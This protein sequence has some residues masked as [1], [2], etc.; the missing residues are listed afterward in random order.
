MLTT[1]VQLVQLQSHAS[2]KHS[3]NVSPPTSGKNV[4]NWVSDK[5][6]GVPL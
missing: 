2:A 4:C 1:L 3:V 6:T 5:L